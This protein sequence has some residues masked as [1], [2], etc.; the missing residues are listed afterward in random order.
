MLLPTTTQTTSG[1][2]IDGFGQGSSVSRC[3]CPLH[4]QGTHLPVNLTLFRRRGWGRRSLLVVLS[5]AAHEAQHLKNSEPFVTL[6]LISCQPNKLKHIRTSSIC[7]G[8]GRAE[9]TTRQRELVSNRPLPL[10]L[11]RKGIYRSLPQHG[12]SDGHMTG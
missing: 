5:A 6:L 7:R 10:M 2:S 4:A 9:C 1:G 12:G 8:G 11:R 3:R